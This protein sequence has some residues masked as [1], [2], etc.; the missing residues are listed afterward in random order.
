MPPIFSRPP[1]RIESLP[2]EI[3]Q[4]IYLRALEPNLA[5]A[6]I[7]IANAVSNTMFYDIFLKHAFWYDPHGIFNAGP[8]HYSAKEGHTTVGGRSHS[9]NLPAWYQR[10][11]INE[12]HRLQAQVANCRWFTLLRFQET[13]QSLFEWTYGSVS[14]HTIHLGMESLPNP[15][16]VQLW[17]EAFWYMPSLSQQGQT[18]AMLGHEKL[19]RIPLL[20]L[21][22][23]PNKLFRGPWDKKQ[24]DLLETLYS[25]LLSLLG[26]SRT[27]SVA[28]Q[29]QLPRPTLDKNECFRGMEKAIT[30]HQETTLLHFLRFL[31]LL[32]STKDSAG[33]IC[34]PILPEHLYRSATLHHPAD[35]T[36]LWR[37][38]EAS[39]TS[40]PDIPEIHG[41]AA[42]A[43]DR[44][45]PLGLSVLEILELNRLRNETN[46]NFCRR[47]LG[48]ILT[49]LVHILGS[50]GVNHRRQSRS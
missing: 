2:V 38:I 27:R 3:I 21:F 10:L 31:E 16:A 8:Q 28:E 46:S 44:G 5:R 22:M 47:A 4:M 36:F 1:A 23:I 12:Q 19:L 32:G 48:R 7:L 39:P 9:C 15:A 18:D 11:T 50:L 45:D 35:S 49:K 6:S 37:L 40:L 14:C 42:A 17:R 41:W 33:R 29:S 13:I 20:R 34:H 25:E 43:R 30:E 26:W 24:T